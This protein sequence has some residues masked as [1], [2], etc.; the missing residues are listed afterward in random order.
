MNKYYRIEAIHEY[1]I[2]YDSRTIFLFGDENYVQGAGEP[3]EEP[4]VEFAMSNKFIKNLT[5]LEQ[6]SGP[7]TVE[8]KT[9]GGDWNE[10]MAIYDAIRG[11]E[12]HITVVSHTHARSMSSIILLAADER[13]LKPHSTF[14]FHAGTMEFHGTYKQFI[15]EAEEARKAHLQMMNIYIDAMQ[16]YG[17][18][19]GKGRK[20]ILRWL[21]NKMNASEEVYLSA[22]EAVEYGFA[23]EVRY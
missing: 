3:T 20:P 15:T 10:G 6:S 8:M 22:E 18:M 7:I 9:C 13:I 11:C 12:E 23:D 4:G 2:D 21:N 5:I 14:M 16:S 19:K 17:K 1:G